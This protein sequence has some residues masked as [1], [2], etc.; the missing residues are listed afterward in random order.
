MVAYFG[1]MTF[2]ARAYNTTSIATYSIQV[3]LDSTNITHTDVTMYN[4]N[5]TDV[6]VLVKAG[7]IQTCLFRDDTGSCL[8]PSITAYQNASVALVLIPNLNW[9]CPYLSHPY[10]SGYS[11]LQWIVTPTATLFISTSRDMAT[12]MCADLYVPINDNN[13][14]VD[15]SSTGSSSGSTASQIIQSSP[16]MERWVIVFLAVFGFIA[17]V[18]VYCIVKCIVKR[19]QPRVSGMIMRFGAL[20]M[21]TDYRERVQRSAEAEIYERNRVYANASGQMDYDNDLVDSDSIL[22]GMGIQNIQLHTP[23]AN[24]DHEIVQ[25]EPDYM[26]HRPLEEA[27]YEHELACDVATRERDEQK[28][29]LHTYNSAYDSADTHATDL[30]HN[31]LYDSVTTTLSEPVAVPETPHTVDII[32][33]TE[34]EDDDTAS[35][36]GSQSDFERTF[37]PRQN[38]FNMRT[39]HQNKQTSIIN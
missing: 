29:P 30:S 9:T 24:K 34:S 6:V 19:P 10:H 31:E 38:R 28:V 39:H 2:V 16:V 23:E 25:T 3:L 35:A 8:L 1:Y 15:V 36:D 21:G 20:E 4:E 27:L 5:Y 7:H 22:Q 11:L 14:I 26:A 32:H 17:L 33:P 18:T 37:I 13:I 12:Q